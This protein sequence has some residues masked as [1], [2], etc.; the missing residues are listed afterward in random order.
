MSTV[1][2][3]EES[4]TPLPAGSKT[5]QVAPPGVNV[6]NTPPLPN[7]QKPPQFT[8]APSSWNVELK[9]IMDYLQSIENEKGL[10]EANKVI[11]WLNS[12]R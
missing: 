7:T 12:K 5:T 8:P 11:A 10:V 2:K 4:K 1:P 9:V 3:G 6:V